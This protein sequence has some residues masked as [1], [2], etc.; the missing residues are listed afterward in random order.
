MRLA[1]FAALAF[2][3]ISAPAALA[4][5]PAPAPASGPPRLGFPLA[6]R[7]GQSCE[8]QHY[9]DRDDGPGMAD[10]HCGRRTEPAHNGIDIR[11]LDLSQM[12][13][14]VDV[15]AE[16][17]GVVRAV[18]DGVADNVIG[19]PIPTA[20]Q[21]GNR[22][23]I[24]HGGGWM[25]DYCHLE[26]G[27]LTV[28]VGDV[29]RAGQAIG[30]VGLSGGTEFPHLHVSVQHLNTFVDPFAPAPGANSSCQ[31]QAPM[32]TPQAL[33]E[34]PYRAGTVLVAGLA[35]RQ[36]GRPE[37]EA[38][39]AP[40]FSATDPVLTIYTRVIGLEAGDQI[41]LT[42]IGPGGAKLAEGRLPPLARDRDQTEG[43]LAHR[44]PAGGW[45]HGTY[46]GV[47]RVWRGGKAVIERR[48]APLAI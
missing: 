8:I 14:G 26:Q 36:M 32:W 16:A 18:R 35:G 12:R 13:R 43:S 21:C 22:V 4:A 48:I 37:I 17:A 5:E 41:E 33:A 24:N 40:A 47:V 7:I 42:L 29:V 28:K 23:A 30:R 15:L 9:V 38:G 25:T 46:A 34:M 11:L 10:Y 44:R 2:A 31:P 1:P 20:Q 6:C 39:G 45:P 19:Q 27:T 3:A